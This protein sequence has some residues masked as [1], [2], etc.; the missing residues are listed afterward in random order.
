MKIN[1]RRA[2]AITSIAALAFAVVPAL[3]VTP[4]AAATSQ[5]GF[6]LDAGYA[7]TPYRHFNNVA[8]GCTE[9][10]GYG[11]YEPCDGGN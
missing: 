9:D 8:P 2:L 7:A 5:D 3:D 11:R 4:A 1:I 6:D 10:L